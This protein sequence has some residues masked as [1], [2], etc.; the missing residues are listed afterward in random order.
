MGSAVQHNPEFPSLLRTKLHRPQVTETTV[1]GAAYAAG[2][3]VGYWN[4]LGDIT[5][6]WALDQEFTPQLPREE[7][8]ALYERWREAVKRSRGWVI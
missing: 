8:Q 2:L 5:A 4:D 7:A 3:A 1:L 6:N